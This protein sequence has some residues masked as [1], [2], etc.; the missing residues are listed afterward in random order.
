MG[1]LIWIIGTLLILTLIVIV[2]TS[3]SNKGI[4]TPDYEVLKRYNDVEIR[5]Y[6]SMIVAKTS[7]TN[8]SFENAGN[9]GFRTIANYIFGGNENN[10]KIAMTAPVVMSM[11]DSASMYFVM[12]KQYSKDQLPKPMGS[13]VSIV[14]ESSKVLAVIRYSGF[15]SD[16]DIKKHCEIL[17]SELNANQIKT[18]GSFMYMGYNAPWDIVNRRNEVAIEVDWLATN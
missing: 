6:P 16:S 15:S 4:E 1:K 2:V 7:L 9:T 8:N 10:Q 17:K 11:G 3:F 18:I 12:P 14:E 5:K 13:N